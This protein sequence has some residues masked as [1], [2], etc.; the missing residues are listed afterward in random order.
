MR[1]IFKDNTTEKNVTVNLKALI[2]FKNVRHGK[3]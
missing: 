1:F 3:V 2:L